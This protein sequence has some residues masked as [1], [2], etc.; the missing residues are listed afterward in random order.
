LQLALGGSAWGEALA[1]ALRRAGVAD[2]AAA[3]EAVFR[4]VERLA[5]EDGGKG[6]VLSLH[7]TP[8]PISR[9]SKNRKII[10]DGVT[11]V[12]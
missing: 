3:E 4:G 2:G 12:W 5:G 11:V 1:G 9:N 7:G 10:L 6:Q 8:S